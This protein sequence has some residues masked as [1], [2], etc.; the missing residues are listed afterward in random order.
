LAKNSNR[1]TITSLIDGEI[2]IFKKRCFTLVNK[3]IDKNNP[4]R[5]DFLLEQENMFSFAFEE[6]RRI[7]LLKKQQTGAAR[8]WKIRLLSAS[9]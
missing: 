8:S 2:N 7:L 9:K 1:A 4:I 3:S 6:V 5:L